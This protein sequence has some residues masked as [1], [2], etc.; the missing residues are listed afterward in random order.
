SVPADVESPSA[1]GILNTLSSHPRKDK[2]KAKVTADVKSTSLNIPPRAPSSSGS[3][4]AR[5]QS[6]DA[7]SDISMK[8]SEASDTL[9]QQIQNSAEA[10]SETKQMKIQAQVV[11]KEL[12]ACNKNAQ[13]EYELKM[14]MVE[15][16]HELSMASERTKQLEL[17]LK[18]EQARIARLEAERHFSAGEEKN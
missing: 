12:K 1:I 10:K 15:N 11:G 8:L 17:E 13:R 18:L 4:A 2:G 14:K 7:G 9:V 6:Q 3:S 5:K 16:E